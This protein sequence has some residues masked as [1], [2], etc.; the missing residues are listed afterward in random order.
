MSKVK[1]ILSVIMA[2]VMVLAMS[3]P[4]FA[5]PT[6]VTGIKSSITVNGLSDKATTTLNLYELAT[7]QLDVETNEYSWK[8]ADWVPANAVTLNTANNK[9]EITNMKALKA[10]VASA[11][12]K[13]TVEEKGTSHTFTEVEIGAY[14][15]TADDEDA[16][17]NLMVANTYDYEGSPA[18]ETGGEP[19]AKDVTVVAKASGHTVTKEATDGFVK[20]GQTVDFTVTTT[21][22]VYKN[23]AGQTLN[24]FQITDEP[25]GLT[26][27]KNTVVVK[28]GN[29]DVTAKT[30]V[31]V[32]DNGKLTVTFTNDLLTEANAGQLVTV[33]YTGTVTSENGY[34]NNAG[35]TS[36]TVDYTST[37][38]KGYT[39]DITL[40]KYAED[41]KT[42]LHGAEFTVTKTGSD[43]ALYFVEKATGEYKLAAEGTEGASQKVVATNGTVKVEGL[44]EGKYHFTETKAPA[45]YSINADGVDATI[46]A[47]TEKNVSVGI[48]INDTKLSALPS[49]GGIGTTIFTIGG[50]AIM[51]VA[52]GL[53]FATRRK[54]QK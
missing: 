22:P 3:V 33:T 36:N 42:V 17:Y 11:T 50:C 30:T 34:N 8:L 38:V 49:T 29:T 37:I 45:G 41:G 1:R 28:I 15:I 48:S 5:A 25:N 26:I 21:F 4:T 31:D 13:A 7:L 47:S 54:T 53:F 6:P 39:G 14:V 35:A 12:A 24:G 9:Y 18:E 2:M 10:A 20:V 19:V 16:E 46:E 40:T 43:E 52:A 44:D 27:G 23:D 51:I 32:A